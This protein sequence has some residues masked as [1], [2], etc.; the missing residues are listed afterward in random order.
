MKLSRA[1]L[2]PGEGRLR[3]KTIQRIV[4]GLGF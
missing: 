4:E 1:T 2:C 3:F